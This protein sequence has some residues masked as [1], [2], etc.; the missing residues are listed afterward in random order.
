[1]SASD[2]VNVDSPLDLHI[3]HAAQSSFQKGTCHQNAH[4][5]APDY[6]I[7]LLKIG[8]DAASSLDNH[9]AMEWT[10]SL[11][12]LFFVLPLFVAILIIIIN[13]FPIRRARKA[14]TWSA[15]KERYQGWN[16]K[17]ETILRIRFKLCNGAPCGALR[18]LPLVGKLGPIPPF[19][20][21]L[22]PVSSTR[23]YRTGQS[24]MYQ[25]PTGAPKRVCKFSAGSKCRVSRLHVLEGCSTFAVLLLI[26]SR[27][28]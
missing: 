10:W 12:L 13:I 6:C 22:R 23:L 9:T 28:R 20:H 1:M 4:V 24:Y 2:V 27:Q 17:L 11:V 19:S 26:V 21:S 18:Q 14:S 3:T 5:R 25:R 16:I 15:K 7:N 8:L